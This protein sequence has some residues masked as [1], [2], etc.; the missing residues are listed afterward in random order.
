MEINTINLQNLIESDFEGNYK[1]FANAINLNSTTVYRVLTG[2]SNPGQKFIA[3]LMLLCK[4]KK[5]DF[6]KY[7]FLN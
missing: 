4:K 3:N 5:Y 1:L 6:D 2:R 7:I